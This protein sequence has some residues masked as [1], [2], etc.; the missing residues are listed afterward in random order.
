MNPIDAALAPRPLSGAS[1]PEC[2]F[3]NAVV[4]GLMAGKH[5]ADPRGEHHHRK[6]D[7]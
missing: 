6:Y 3:A 1:L 2:I 7:R 5:A 4:H